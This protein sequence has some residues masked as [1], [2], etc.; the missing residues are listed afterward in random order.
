MDDVACKER[1]VNRGVWSVY[2]GTH[3]AEGLGIQYV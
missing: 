1:V 3:E 2:I